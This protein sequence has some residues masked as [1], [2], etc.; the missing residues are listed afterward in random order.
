MCAMNKF[1]IF[2]LF[3]ATV[4]PSEIAE[5]ILTKV[6]I[7]LNI[8]HRIHLLPR[9]DVIALVTVSSVCSE[10]YAIM[11][12]SKRSRRKIRNL[13]RHSKVISTLTL[14]LFTDDRCVF[15][16]YYDYLILRGSLHWP[17]CK[18]Y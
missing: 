18:K 5:M 10:W 16:S 6:I 12:R 8:N 2:L 3:K 15:K 9:G 17:A 11:F 14:L 13:V 1:V 7:A 4:F